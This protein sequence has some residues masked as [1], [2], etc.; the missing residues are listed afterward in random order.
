MQLSSLTREEMS[1]WRRRYKWVGL[2]VGVVGTWPPPPV[3]NR[4]ASV[5]VEDVNGA[6][7]RSRE[8]EEV[9]EVERKFGVLTRAFEKGDMG[10]V[11][12]FPI[13]PFNFQSNSHNYLTGSVSHFMCAG[14][15]TNPKIMYLNL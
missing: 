6:R 13:Q 9:E 11:S 5:D 1:G 12:Q 15:K 10:F 3:G 2:L 14:L 8:V 7:G 4:G